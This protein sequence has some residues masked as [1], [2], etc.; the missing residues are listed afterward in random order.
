VKLGLARLEKEASRKSRE[1]RV[2]EGWNTAEAEIRGPWK[3]K[4]GT[5]R[6]KK[7]LGELSLAHRRR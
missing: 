5:C 2:E 4:L 7:K 6:R 1:K 3:R